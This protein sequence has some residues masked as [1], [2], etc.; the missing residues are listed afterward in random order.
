MESS[1]DKAILGR[2]DQ[3][4]AILFGSFTGG[5]GHKQ[6]TMQR[7]ADSEKTLIF[8]AGWFSH[9]KGNYPLPFGFISHIQTQKNKNSFEII[10]DYDFTK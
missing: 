7:F 4:S 6:Y 8:Y 3:A 5:D 2:L 1:K 9:G 10:I